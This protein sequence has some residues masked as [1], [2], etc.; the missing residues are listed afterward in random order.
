MTTPTAHPDAFGLRIPPSWEEIDL[1]PA[2]RDATLAATVGRRIDEAPELRPHRTDLVR[3]FRNLART[4]YDA[5]GRYCAVFAQPAGEGV[6]PGAIT[7]TA[8]PQPP[9]ESGLSPLDAIVDQLHRA[10]TPDGDGLWQSTRITELEHAGAAVQV[11]GVQDV[12]L[13]EAG[14]Q[15]RCVT[16]STFVPTGDH[17]L[18]VT[19][20]SPAIDLADALLDLFGAVTGTLTLHELGPDEQA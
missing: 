16:L 17:V 5:G 18:L 1:N 15:L 12:D 14:Y 6:I 11:F 4:A 20:T 9:A 19:G 3:L 7:V 8:L 13:N 10:P 2:T